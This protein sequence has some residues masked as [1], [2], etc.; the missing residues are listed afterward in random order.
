MSQPKKSWRGL[1][2]AGVIVAIVAIVIVVHGVWTRASENSRLRD[3]TDAQALPTVAVISPS[4]DANSSG[5]ELP[6]RLEAYARAPI[7][8]RISGYVKSY[9]V[10][11]GSKVKAGQVLAEIE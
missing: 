2:L 1:R 7:Y 4:S 3:W 5:L 10:D 9:N 11:I 8:A 6:G